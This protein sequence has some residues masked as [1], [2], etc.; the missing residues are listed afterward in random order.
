MEWPNT[1]LYL[2]GTENISTQAPYDVRHR[3]AADNGTAMGSIGRLARY[4]LRFEKIPPSSI[5]Y[6]PGYGFQPKCARVAEYKPETAGRHAYLDD[7]ANGEFSVNDPLRGTRN[8]IL[9]DQFDKWKR[10]GTREKMYRDMDQEPWPLYD[11]GTG[12]MPLGDLEPTAEG[13]FAFELEKAM[14]NETTPIHR[15]GG[16]SQKRY[17][18]TRLSI[19]GLHKKSDFIEETCANFINPKKCKYKPYSQKAFGRRDGQIEYRLPWLQV[20]PNI[21]K[22]LK[23]L[24]KRVWDE[25]DE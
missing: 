23:D 10:R 22:H 2:R 13:Q 15:Y 11:Q 25:S 1:G 7:P 9:T 6:T 24:D 3:D 17:I 14:R 16:P 18:Y 19:M 20:R 21:V 5:A 8:N 4:A 12:P